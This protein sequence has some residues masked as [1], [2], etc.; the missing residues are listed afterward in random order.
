ME[1]NTAYLFPAEAL[2]GSATVIDVTGYFLLRASWVPLPAGGF[3]VVPLEEE[4][5]CSTNL[6][7]EPVGAGV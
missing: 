1:L 4:G 2:I 6:Q 7:W 3:A 5:S